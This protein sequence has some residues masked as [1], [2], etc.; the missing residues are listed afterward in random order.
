MKG[1]W[2]R[3]SP[4]FPAVP[5]DARRTCQVREGGVWAGIS[6]PISG[7]GR[8]GAR[9]PAPPRGTSAP[10]RRAA[11]WAGRCGRAGAAT[12][13]VRCSFPRAEGRKACGGTRRGEAH[14]GEKGPGLV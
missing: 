5:A 14:G 7:A 2:A 6:R 1:V 3:I 12:L 4:R 9:H 13:P 8:V 10:A 11:M